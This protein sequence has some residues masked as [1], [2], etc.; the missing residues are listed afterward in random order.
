MKQ[1]MFVLLC[2]YITSHPMEKPSCAHLVAPIVHLEKTKKEQEKQEH[3]LLLAATQNMIEQKSDLNLPFKDG[4]F[5]GKTILT[6]A[7]EHRN[8]KDILIMALV[9][10]ADPNKIDGNKYSPLKR[11]VSAHCRTTFKY[12]IQRGATAK[13]QGLVQEICGPWHDTL[14]K[15]KKRKNV[16]KC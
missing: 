9:A 3:A 1:K 14:H 6:A 12:L 10:G 5:A 7:A 15:K 4:Q 16:L 2:F 13:D 11:A 8:F